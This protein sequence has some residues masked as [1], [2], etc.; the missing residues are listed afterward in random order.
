MDLKW[1]F[2]KVLVRF[3]LALFKI[4]AEMMEREVS[5]SELPEDKKREIET[6]KREIR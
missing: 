1:I 4:L 6:K 5:E 2:L 3:R